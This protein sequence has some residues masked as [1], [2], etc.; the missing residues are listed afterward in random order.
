MKDITTWDSMFLNTILS[1]GN[2]LYTCISTC[3]STKKELLL[4]TDVTELI[5]VHNSNVYYL[6]CSDSLAGDVF[7]ITEPFYSLILIKYSSMLN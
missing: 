3:K 5:S 4:L 7:M 6:Q 2:N 1:V